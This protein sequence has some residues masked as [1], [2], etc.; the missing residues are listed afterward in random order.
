PVEQGQ[1]PLLEPAR[2]RTQ[3]RCLRETV[4]VLVFVVRR[5]SRPLHLPG[6]AAAWGALVAGDAEEVTLPG[7]EVER[8]CAVGAGGVEVVV[9]GQA[10]P[11]SVEQSQHRVK[12]TRW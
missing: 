10:V 5:G 11:A 6:V 3:V 8:E 7:G 4:I 1:A 12:R 2:E 9:V